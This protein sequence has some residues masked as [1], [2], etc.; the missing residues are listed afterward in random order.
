M[1]AAAATSSDTT[2]I[3]TTDTRFNKQ[4]FIFTLDIK[5]T[6]QKN[7]EFTGKVKAFIEDNLDWVTQKVE[8]HQNENATKIGFTKY[9][10]NFYSDKLLSIADLF[11]CDFVHSDKDTNTNYNIHMIFYCLKK[12]ELF[13]KSFI[14]NDSITMSLL[15]RDCMIRN[16]I[17]DDEFHKYW[18][19]YAQD[20]LIQDL[21]TERIMQITFNPP[22]YC[23][24]NHY[25]HQ[26]DMITSYLK[27]HYESETIRFTTDRVFYLGNMLRLWF[28]YTN[29]KDENAF[30]HD[31][32]F[33]K[34]FIIGGIDCT[35]TGHGKTYCALTYAIYVGMNDPTQKT[36]TLICVPDHIKDHWYSQLNQHFVAG[37]YTPYIT[38]ASYTDVK[39]MDQQFYE[40]HTVFIGDELHLLYG[41]NENRSTLYNKIVNSHNFKRRWGITATPSTAD[42]NALWYINQLV[43]RTFNGNPITHPAA[44]RYKYVLK[45]IKKHGILRRNVESS[46]KTYLNLPPVT[47]HNI[48]CI[49]SQEEWDFYNSEMSADTNRN[50]MD[51]MK[52]CV[53]LM[54]MMMD[55]STN[56]NI[57]TISKWKEHAFNTRVEQAKACREVLHV[58]TNKLKNV[59]SEIKKFDMLAQP[60]SQY[61]IADFQQRAQHIISEIK[62]QEVIVASRD[63]VVERYRATLAN[64]EASVAK[65]DEDVSAEM[66]SD[67]TFD[68]DKIC[69]ICYEPYYGVIA[70]FPTITDS[71]GNVRCGHYFH[72]RCYE[73]YRRTT[74]TN[75]CPMCRSVAETGSIT[76]VGRSEEKRIIGAKNK[77]IIELMTVNNDQSFIIFT[78]FE[79]YI[80][81]LRS[82]LKSNEISNMDYDEYAAEK[83]RLDGAFPN[84]RAL[85]LSSNKNAC[86]IDLQEFH[87]I[88][89]VSPFLNNVHGQQVEKQLIGRCDRIGQT[90]AINVYRLYIEGT[91]EADIYR[92]TTDSSQA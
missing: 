29:M 10:N 80:P 57:T 73:D 35:H 66:D 65:S 42:G 23:K 12:E 38:I 7:I 56:K 72:K 17:T 47:I 90:H 9:R 85:I 19:L 69:S 43:I 60:A 26:L 59:L 27:I 83:K 25:L 21:S 67:D 5:P 45:E 3:M 49:F 54:V 62:A 41:N 15:Y 68:E 24:T 8:C 89:I 40:S 37:D 13:T 14:M 28:N 52:F 53:D 58:L 91:I 20:N 88:I 78:H 46:T 6:E 50:I 31:S 92:I 34:A 44:G 79:N 75:N 70:M 2:A 39:Q 32:D 77:K 11:Y 61:I 86:G 48:P 16:N 33:P 81:S 55:H 1:A 22:E 30:F 18:N 74:Q 76:Y 51:I 82:L 71:M 36:K 4:Y 63:A 87:N 64:L 84:V